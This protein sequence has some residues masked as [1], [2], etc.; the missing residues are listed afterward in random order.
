VILV[1]LIGSFVMR[2]SGPVMVQCAPIEA[3][4]AATNSQAT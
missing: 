1:L 2:V 4:S 3:I